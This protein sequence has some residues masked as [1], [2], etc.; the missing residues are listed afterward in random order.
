MKTLHGSPA[1]P[2]VVGNIVFEIHAGAAPT[3]SS[4]IASL[5]PIDGTRQEENIRNT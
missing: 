4:S 5:P 3:R 1:L 2:S